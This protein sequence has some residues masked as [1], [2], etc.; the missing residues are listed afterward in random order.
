LEDWN[1]HEQ[2]AVLSQFVRW[3][4]NLVRLGK[5]PY[6]EALIA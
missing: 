2:G 6:E 5:V 3:S 1:L 4:G